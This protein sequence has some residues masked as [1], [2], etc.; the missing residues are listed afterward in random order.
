M[1]MK[2][3]CP[4]MVLYL[5]ARTCRE[6]EEWFRRFQMAAIIAETAIGNKEKSISRT[7]SISSL[8]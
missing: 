1:I 3:D 7:S 5:F 8:R 4:D 6:K 2:E